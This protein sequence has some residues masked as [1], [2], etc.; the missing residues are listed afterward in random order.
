VACT[1]T[2]NFSVQIS[3]KTPGDECQQS[4]R[5]NSPSVYTNVELS[6]YFGIYADTEEPITSSVMASS[7]Q[8][9]ELA[10]SLLSSTVQHPAH[11][12]VTA[13]SVS[14]LDGGVSGRVVARGWS[15]PPAAN[16]A[17][18]DYCIWIVAVNAGSEPAMV[19]LSITGL[20]DY[21]LPIGVNATTPF[22]PVPHRQIPLAGGAEADERFLRDFVGSGETNIYQVGCHVAGWPG[23]CGDG[24]ESSFNCGIANPSF[25]DFP[26][27]GYP[28]GWVRRWPLDLLL[29]N[30]DHIDHIDFMHTIEKFQATHS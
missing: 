8:L 16:G 3:A 19:N 12:N 14:G 5:R 4:V 11:P 21:K 29:N 13:L 7:M 24:F 27:A 9:H 18:E 28:L 30:I 25:E 15:E 1:T 22:Q 26:I 23:N 20:A 6:R 10:P 2:C 17:Q